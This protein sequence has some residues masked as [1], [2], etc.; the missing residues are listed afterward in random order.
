[1]EKTARKLDSP[2]GERLVVAESAFS[3]RLRVLVLILEKAV[4]TTDVT[5]VSD[6][7]MVAVGASLHSA[8]ECGRGSRPSRKRFPFAWSGSSVVSQLPDSGGL[9]VLCGYGKSFR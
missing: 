3:L 7:E 4:G 9:L 2:F 8:G 5:D 6:E 1:M